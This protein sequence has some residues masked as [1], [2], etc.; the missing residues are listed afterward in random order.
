MASGATT[1]MGVSSGGIITR[2]QTPY[3]RMQ[4]S[5]QPTYYYTNGATMKFGSVDQQVGSNWNNVTGYWTCPVAGYY[6]VLFNAIGA[7]ANGISYG[8]PYIYKNGATYVYSH[9]NVSG[10][11]DSMS[12]S[13]VMQ[14]A[15]NDTISFGVNSAGG[16]GTGNGVYG[17]G[18][19]CHYSIALLG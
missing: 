15:A 5:G 18:N 9:W 7:N 19:H 11:W 14:C 3:V 16:A 6:L 12:L 17:P 8:Y 10:G 4:T 1:L 2:P 13:T